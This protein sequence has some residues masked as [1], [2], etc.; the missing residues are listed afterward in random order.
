[1]V[2]FVFGVGGG[3]LFGVGC[4]GLD[5][6][7]SRCWWLL[8]RSFLLFLCCIIIWVCCGMFCFLCLALAR[9]W[10]ICSLSIT[11]VG[12]GAMRLMF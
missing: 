7:I 12:F 11:G 10:F 5:W 8:A 3:S 2:D 1:M 6:V 4:V 9:S